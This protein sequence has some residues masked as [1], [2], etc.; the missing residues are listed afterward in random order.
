MDMDSSSEHVS[1]STPPTSVSDTHS[2]R[3]NKPG[4]EATTS[5]QQSPGRR[6][7]RARPS[8]NY[9]VVEQFNA[10]H[11]ESSTGTRNAS[12]LS[13]RTLVNRSE[14]GEE[15][16][17][18]DEDED[19]Q[20][21]P[22]G[23]PK[24]KS[25]GKV[26]RRPSMKERVKKMASSAKSVLGKRTR[27]AVDA[28]KRKLG[29]VEESQSP[30]Q[31]KLLKELDM[32]TGNIWDEMDLDVDVP[33]PPVKR[34]KTSKAPLQE[35]AQPAVAGPMQKT[36]TGKKVKKWQPHG[37]YAGQA[38]DFDPNKPAAKKLQ[39]KR[40]ESSGSGAPVNDE[41]A[42][43]KHKSI[44]GFHLPMYGYLDEEKTRSFR[45]PYDVYAPC[46][47]Q[48]EKPKDWHK[49]NK[50]R[51]VGDAKELWAKTGK[52]A[53]SLCVCA[54]PVPGDDELGCGDGCLNRIMQYECDA[55]NCPLPP[56]LCSNRPF[57][58]I[59]ARTKKGGAYD[60]GV[61]VVKTEKRGHGIRAARSF[62]PQQVIM[63]YTGEIITEEECQRRMREVYK[64][65]SCY[66]L[67]ELERNL[68]IDGTK[69]SMAR[70][71]NHSCD[72]NC[73]VRMMKV[74]GTPR[75]AI[76]A[77]DSGIMT[78]EE[79]T[80]DYNFDNF[81]ET[82]QPC[83]CGAA[84]CRGYLGKRLNAD[85]IKKLQ[86]E[87][88]EKQRIAAEEAAKAAKKAQTEK[89]KKD[90]RGPGWQGWVAVDDPKVK[91][92][93]REAKRQ[94]EEAEKNSARAQRLA[95]RG[96]GRRGSLSGSSKPEPSRVE[97]KKASPNRRRTVAN[98][99]Q[100]VRPATAPAEAIED[101]SDEDVKV[102]FAKAASSR[103]TSSRRPV[104]RRTTSTGSKF[105]ED[106]DLEDRPASRSSA[107][108]GITKKTTVS[109]EIQRDTIV[110]GVSTGEA[111]EEEDIAASRK[112]FADELS[113][114]GGAS[115]SKVSSK[116]ALIGEA[117]KGEKAPPAKKQ[118][119]AAGGSIRSK[120]AAAV[121][122]TGKTLRQSTLSF[123]KLG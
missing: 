68:V 6:S 97:K 65:K 72:P 117:S 93:L 69:G 47:K 50:N 16:D 107:R 17:E 86:K 95:N 49:V 45:I 8:V 66:Y 89:A 102:A 13:G 121:R 37:L 5:Q 22:N 55:T 34:A 28:G 85:Q 61:E 54:Q 114:A 112:S 44:L 75:M 101:E 48:S 110:E 51:L 1:A 2:T 81:G 30:Q 62:R 35:I 38:L 87:E 106:L 113:N 94:K 108:T 14:M 77:G 82:R 4:D 27:D 20:E 53:S 96:T 103:P 71:I 59:T 36:S 74:N 91:E 79:L 57:A 41:N 3:S 70:F 42:N 52:M 109:L 9:N 58:E 31:K 7:K 100:L 25:P 78:G 98:A 63:E 84:N 60:V 12:G 15:D 73:E 120:V 24:A 33:L 88:A 46:G 104:H 105:T 29:R 99:E 11:A 92:Q 111:V 21:L 64:D 39:K 67:M 119:V 90:S 76:F 123:P 18:E 26:Q 118:K 83:Y 56:E 32:G 19:E 122:S 116:A 115:L 23:S 80:Y 43:P 40:P 10:I